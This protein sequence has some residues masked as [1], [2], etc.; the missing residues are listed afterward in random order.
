MSKYFLSFETAFIASF[1]TGHGFLLSG[2]RPF[3]GPLQATEQARAEVGSVRAP[4]AQ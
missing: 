1:Y 2:D 4:Q 3:S